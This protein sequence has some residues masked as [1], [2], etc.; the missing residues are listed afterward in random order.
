[1]SDGRPAPGYSNTTHHQKVPDD[2]IKEWL[3]ELIS[4]SGYAYGYHKLTWALRRDYD[5]IINKKKVYRLCRELGILRR[6]HRKHVHHPR[7][8]AKNRKI[9]GSNQ[10]WETDQIRLY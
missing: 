4:G 3:M 5:L 1:M 6:Q 9:T 10:L 2:Q 7:R 8:I